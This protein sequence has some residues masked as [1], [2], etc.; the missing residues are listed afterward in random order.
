MSSSLP[1]APGITPLALAGTYP[2][3]C[4]NPLTL[5]R[6]FSSRRRP[7]LQQ[8][9]A[10]CPRT[11]AARRG[12]IACSRSR[13]AGLPGSRLEGQVL[14]APVARASGLASR[15]GAEAGGGHQPPASHPARSPPPA[16]RAAGQAPSRCGR[17]WEMA[18]SDVGGDSHPRGS[19]SV[20]VTVGQDSC[21]SLSVTERRY[22]RTRA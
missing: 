14:P 7:Q 18:S 9:P 6:V 3:G 4:L 12:R 17:A 1:T 2:P 10:P 19:A 5:D 22:P 15:L 13:P 20:P 11:T 21:V 16:A 8:P